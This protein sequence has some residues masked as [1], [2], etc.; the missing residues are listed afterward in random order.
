M[1]RVIQ[2]K[3]VGCGACADICPRGAIAI[4]DNKAVIDGNKCVD[5]GRCMQVCPEGAIQ[6]SAGL[7]QNVDFGQGRVFARPVFGM[8]GSMW[9]GRVRGRGMGRGMGK[10]LGR[11]P[12][13]GWGRGRGG[14]ARGSA[15]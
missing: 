11:G 2:E 9:Q 6:P 1:F 15:Y 13:D 12:R 10:G 3:C 7:H 14:G 5:C 8:G 4:V